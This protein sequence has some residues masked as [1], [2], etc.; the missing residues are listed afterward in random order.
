M[1]IALPR[2]RLLTAL[3]AFASV[4]ACSA[5][6]TQTVGY[7]V[8]E[9]VH[10]GGSN[11]SVE[12][13]RIYGSPEALTDNLVRSGF[14]DCSCLLMKPADCN[15]F[16]LKLESIPVPE[17]LPPGVVKI[18]IPKTAD[19][20]KVYNAISKSPNTT[21]DDLKFGVIRGR[22]AR[23]SSEHEAQTNEA[24]DSEAQPASNSRE[25]QVICKKDAKLCISDSSA[26]FV[27]GCEGLGELEISTDGEV[28]LSLSAGSVKPPKP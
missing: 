26:S 17:P 21:L 12:S 24:T 20:V 16:L 7:L 22:Q 6:A 2:P 14:F 3:L 19:F 23:A 28:S 11:V 15:L 8:K 18:V 13:V 1:R 4:C 25:P 9:P 5:Q 27:I 10:I